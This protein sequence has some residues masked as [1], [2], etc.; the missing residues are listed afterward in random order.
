MTAFNNK[1]Q[2]EKEFLSIA[3]WGAGWVLGG[4]GNIRIVTGEKKKYC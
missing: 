1:V 2:V 3:Q 4:K